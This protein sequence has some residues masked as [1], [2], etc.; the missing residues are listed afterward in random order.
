[1]VFF[2]ERVLP[3]I[4][5]RLPGVTLH[6]VGSDPTPEVMNL[7]G[8]GVNVSGLVP[9]LADRFDRRRTF[10]APLRCGAGVR[11]NLLLSMA[12]RLPVVASTI[13]AEGIPAQNGVDLLIADEPDGPAV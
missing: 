11:S 7:H 13:A 3:R 4:V 6:V 12:H 9:R 8:N 10:A 5:R 2:V 1:M